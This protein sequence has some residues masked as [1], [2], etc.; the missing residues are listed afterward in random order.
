MLALRQACMPDGE[1]T[2]PVASPLHPVQLV[3]SLTASALAR[4]RARSPDCEPPRPAASTLSHWRACW[5]DGAAAQPAA[6]TLARG[7]A[8]W[9]DGE[10]ARPS[11]ACAPDGE[12]AR[13]RRKPLALRRAAL[14]AAEAARPTSL[15]RFGRGRASSPAAE[16]ARRR[17]SALRHRCARAQ[18]R[19]TGY[20]RVLRLVGGSSARSAWRAGHY[21]GCGFAG[22]GECARAEN[23][24]VHGRCG[25]SAVP[26]SRLRLSGLRRG[27]A[28]LDAAEPSR[29]LRS[30]LAVRGCGSLTA[31]GVTLPAAAKHSLLWRCAPC[32]HVS[33]AG[34][35][36]R[37]PSPCRAA[38]RRV[39]S[40]ATLARPAQPGLTRSLVIGHAPWRAAGGRA[41]TPVTTPLAVTARCLPAVAR[42]GDDFSVTPLQLALEVAGADA[43]LR[44]DAEHGRVDNQ[45]PQ[46]LHQVE[47]SDGVRGEGGVP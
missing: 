29:R 23:R 37:R 38:C 24:D 8:R 6:S 40:R 43:L 28:A 13:R 3:A 5:S 10:L 21:R 31:V 36:S 39:S 19:R 44:D 35:V 17:A 12:L 9:P 4:W 42:A 47:P 46:L 33:Q 26:P 30:R 14:P 16:R 20:G 32:R 11:R 22:G 1:P 41:S 45:H 34:G 18:A 25:A 27:A 15:K 2:R 7:R